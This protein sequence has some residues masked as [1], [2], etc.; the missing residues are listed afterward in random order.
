MASDILFEVSTPL[1]F[2]VHVTRGYWEFVVT[3]NHPVMRERATEVQ[4]ALH[5]PDEVRQSRSDPAAFLFSRAEVSGHWSCAV[6]N[7]LNDTGFLITTYPTDAIKEGE[8][9]W[10]RSRFSMSG[11]AIP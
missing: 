9:V 7:Q 11:L 6:T 8:W 4:D 2:R 10:G 5:T 3:V 1:G